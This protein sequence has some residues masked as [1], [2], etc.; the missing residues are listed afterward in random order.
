MPSM[1]CVITAVQEKEEEGWS[2][3]NRIGFFECHEPGNP[4]VV[5]R[6]IVFRSY[7]SYYESR[8]IYKTAQFCLE[9]V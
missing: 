4:F 5:Q 7:C 8:P 9:E 3:E 2:P 1:L 6:R